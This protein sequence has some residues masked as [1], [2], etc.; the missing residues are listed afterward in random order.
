MQSTQQKEIYFS[1]FV[2]I[3]LRKKW[4]ILI[5]LVSA[6]LPIIYYNKVSPPVYEA[7]TKIVCEETR[8]TIQNFDIAQARLNKSFIENK[9]QELHSW[10][11]ANNVV[12]I[13][14]DSVLNVFP[15]PEQLTSNYEKE[16]FYTLAIQKSI[17]ANGIPNS[18]VISIAAQ[19]H[20]AKVACI[21]ANTIAEVLKQ[22]NLKAILG[23]IGNVRKTI[24][25]QLEYFKERVEETE[26]SLRE[27]KE[28]NKITYLDQESQEIFQRITQAEIEYNRIKSSHEAAKNRF[29]FIQN[30]LVQERKDLVPSITETTSPWAQKLKQNLID[31]EVQYTTLKVQD[32]DDN[33]P[34]MKKL[35]SQIEET[36][37][38]L[39]N[40][41]LKIANGEGIADPLSEIQRN[42]EEAAS[43]EIE[44]HTYDAQEKALGKVL[45]GYNN[46]L[47][48]VPE[49]ELELGRLIRDKNVAD[50]IYTML[51]KQREEAKITAAEKSGNI[52]IIDPAR[53]PKYP[54]KPRKMLNLIISFIVGG[55]IGVGL[56][57]LIESLD[58]SIKTI[59]EVENIIDIPV[60]S[61]IPQ[62]NS[63]YNGKLN[64][65]SNKDSNYEIS[66]LASK[67]IV[68]RDPKS[69][70]SE[71]FRTLRTSL[72]FAK[73]NPK[74]KT[75]LVT[76]SRPSEGKSLIAA[77]LAISTTQL[78]LKT[79]LVDLDLRKPVQHQLFEKEQEPGIMDIILSL[80]KNS[81][82]KQID[83]LNNDESNNAH[84][85]QEVTSLFNK[86]RH[87]IEMGNLHLLTCGK[88]PPNPSEIL[89]SGA[90]KNMF[91][92]F[93]ENYDVIIL[94]A[95][96][97]L[98][99]T[100]A[101][102]VARLTDGI[103][104]VIRA[105]KNSQKEILRTKELLQRAK[106]IVIGS[107]L[108]GVETDSYYGY[109][110]DSKYYD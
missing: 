48:S 81:D 102:I 14:P 17:S 40:E 89:S 11:L 92:S 43:L 5:C 27:Y 67:L 59:E 82:L 52:R 9:I 85:V 62:I 75:L 26:K 7:T 66:K 30:K 6:L 3:L 23:E 2:H 84:Y 104:I 39:I 29:K 46:I 55:S 78:G 58:K 64:N 83:I 90:I 54:I 101:T 38:N 34:Q 76:S 65:L 12:K 24:E 47:K 25:D 94:D 21:I 50:N 13:L 4:L 98:T 93:K 99:V 105:G 87:Q 20:S 72:E 88:I 68:G 45:N 61:T 32:Y 1:N 33:H 22:R 8:S 28:R 70:V 97:V 42:L 69:P 73:D 44:I 71:A 79:L 106:G 18:D 80:S 86:A 95:P 109:Y 63:R 103:V 37:K 36:K 15:L 31:L 100:D 51:L 53:I 49:K 60:L 74:A 10:S 107:V 91:N 110:H 35:K 56:S 16:E 77:N 19:A 41:T 108:N 57:F 96:P